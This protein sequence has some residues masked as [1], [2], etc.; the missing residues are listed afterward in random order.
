MSIVDSCSVASDDK[1]RPAPGSRA[2]R[3]TMPMVILL[4]IASGLAIGNLYWAQPLLAQI[5]GD[6][7]VS[8]ADG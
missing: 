6:L 2:I 5:T 7:G 3:L 8:V 1:Y 4:T